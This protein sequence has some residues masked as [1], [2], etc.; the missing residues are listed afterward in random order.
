MN[1]NSTLSHIAGGVGQMELSGKANRAMGTR[2]S[3]VL[4][5]HITGSGGSYTYRCIEVNPNIEVGKLVGDTS[6]VLGL[7]SINLGHA[8]DT[9]ITRSSA[10]QLAV[11]NNPVGIKV[12]VPAS[13]TA[14]GVPGQWAADASYYYACIA[15][16]TWVRSPLST[17]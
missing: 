10:G 5:G 2:S 3:L 9:T 16:N 11:E 6:T 7:G 8:S 1:A 13:A 15:T 4:T 12:S 14:A 17:W